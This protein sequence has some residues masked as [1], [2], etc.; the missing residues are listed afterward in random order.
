MDRPILW[1]GRHAVSMEGALT[2]EPVGFG[3]IVREAAAEKVV[4][5]LLAMVQAGQLQPGDK[6]PG[7]RDLAESFAISRPTVRE[8]LRALTILG[9]LKTRQGGGIT[10]SSLKASDLL[11][12]LTF[13]LSL[14]DVEVDRLYHARQLIEGEIAALAA[15]RCTARDADALEAMIAHQEEVLDRPELYRVVDTEFHARL[16]AMSDNPFLERAAASMN[17]LGQEFR[18]TAS[19][20]QEVIRE[21]VRDHRLIVTALR[22][23]DPQAARQAMVDHMRHVLETTKQTRQDL[24]GEEQ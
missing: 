23:R 21:A 2:V 19:E 6:L 10:V 5:R 9:V 13:F 15:G 17:V 18:K 16:A 22:N 11:G 7:E 14:H 20:T 12:P 4:H 3:P 1:L 24:A 8:A